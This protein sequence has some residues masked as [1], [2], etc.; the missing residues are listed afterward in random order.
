MDDIEEAIAVLEPFIDA[1]VSVPCI[2]ARQVVAA[3]RA[4]QK[5]LANLTDIV[6]DLIMEDENS[7]WP[8]DMFTD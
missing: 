8:P 1:A 5:E 4:A 2:I 7:M 6:E 3:L